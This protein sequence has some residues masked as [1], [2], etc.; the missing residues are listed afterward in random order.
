MGAS[1]IPGLG[2]CLVTGL[3]ADG[4]SLA[5]VLVHARV[6]E[7]DDIGADVRLEDG[8]EGHG[9]NHLTLLG[10][11]VD[12]RTGCLQV[13]GG[14]ADVQSL[15]TKT[16]VLVHHRIASDVLLPALTKLRNSSLKR[17]YKGTP[18]LPGGPSPRVGRTV[19]PS[20]KREC[21][22]DRWKTS[23]TGPNLAKSRRDPYTTST[24]HR[25]HSSAQTTA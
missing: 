18:A 11:H 13:S 17:Y 4:V 15:G 20:L 14:G 24:P 9:P 7:A 5:L 10:V 19:S 1:S 12:E 8:G 3:L 2:G 25:A 16:N 6:H 22:S 21:A 23:A